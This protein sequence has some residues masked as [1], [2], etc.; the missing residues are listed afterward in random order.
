MYAY[1]PYKYIYAN[2]NFLSHTHTYI[3][4]HIVTYYPIHTCM[5]TRIHT[6]TDRGSSIQ[7]ANGAILTS[8]FTDTHTHAC[9][10]SADKA[11]SIHT[12]TQPSKPSYTCTHIHAHIHTYM[13]SADTHIYTHT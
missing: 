11:S 5:H 13:Y 9:V 1:I 3:Y 10:H 6:S 2:V 4:T 7:E 8:T 12:C